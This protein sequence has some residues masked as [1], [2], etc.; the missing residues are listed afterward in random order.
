MFERPL[1]ATSPQNTLVQPVLLGAVL[2]LTVAALYLR[3]FGA[4]DWHVAL[5]GGLAAWLLGPVGFRD[6]IATVADSW[7]IEAFFLGLMLL[8]A[9]AEASG[10][11]ARLARSLRRTRPGRPRLAAILLAAAAITAI[12]S[13]DATP[14]VL[15]PAIFALAL[16][17]RDLAPAAFG[18]TFMADGASLV[19]PVS[20]P[21]NLLFYERF[22][23][24]FR[25][26]S[27]HI[28]P[29]A[30]A[31]V[32]ALAIVTLV[33]APSAPRP[34]VPSRRSV[35]PTENPALELAAAMLVP[36][37]AIAYVAAAI[38]RIPLGLVTLAG[39]LLMFGLVLALRGD[40]SPYR[41]HFSWGLLIFVA[42]L[43]LLTESVSDAGSLG[44]LATI[45]SHLADTPPL[46]AIAGSAL[47]AA[48]VSNLLNN[49]P[50]ALLLAVA[51]EGVTGNRDGLLAGT[52]IGC[53]IGANFTM[54]G[55]LST[56]FWLNL[57]RSHGLTFGP[58]GYARRAFLPT[59]TAL[60]A[61]TL[62]AWMT[63]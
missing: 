7:S 6:G 27:L 11:Y 58:A 31:G 45:L 35:A 30:L 9:G 28:L 53:S 59:L 61:A 49:W 17:D 34:N 1:G 62:V 36:V 50:A 19:L 25:D 16:S 12:F 55:S 47:I 20:N 14:L 18:V 54:V 15:T 8:A 44:W 46:I 5:G 48:V 60:S 22:D 51:I 43:L 33:R 63:A 24:T 40:R 52:L 57:C 10:L 39:G 26:Y 38:E 42:G 37:L 4:K 29:A 32:A 23:L 13:N 2:A 41:K 3:P 21:V 56:V